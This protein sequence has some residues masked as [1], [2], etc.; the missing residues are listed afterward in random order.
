MYK[1]ES[2]LQSLTMSPRSWGL[3]LSLLSIPQ[4]PAPGL[5]RGRGSLLCSSPSGL[6]LAFSL[7]FLGSLTDCEVHWTFHF[8]PHLLSWDV[9][10][11]AP[12]H[13]WLRGAHELS[14][15]VM[16]TVRFFVA[17]PSSWVSAHLMGLNSPPGAPS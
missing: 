8:L 15:A 3:S 4:W 1:R 13:W 9:W 11:T 10:L 16:T 12:P 17:T 14:E 2:T 5:G 7:F 6:F